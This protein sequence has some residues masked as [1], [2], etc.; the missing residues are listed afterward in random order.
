MAVWVRTCA[1]RLL[2][3]C[4]EA[5]FVQIES[6]GLIFDFAVGGEREEDRRPDRT[7]DG[8]EWFQGSTNECGVGNH[9][10]NS[11]IENPNP[12]ACVTRTVSNRH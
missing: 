4:A 8:E 10:Q 6:A 11:P 5:S 12:H 1:S 7:R 3:A 9:S 2:V